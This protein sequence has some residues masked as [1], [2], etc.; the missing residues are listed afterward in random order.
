M[1]AGGAGAILPN[2]FTTKHNFRYVPRMNGPDLVKKLRAQLDANGY[3]DVEVKLIGDVPW[4]RGSSP[5]T[6]IAHAHQKAGELMASIGLGG[7]GRGGAPVL[8]TSARLTDPNALLSDTAAD[9]AGGYWPAYLFA[10]GETG[11]KIGSVSIPMGGRGGGG[12]GGRAHAANEFY[13]VEST[14]TSGGLANAE[15]NAAAAIYQY[16]QLTTV[17]PK[18]KATAGK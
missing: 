17:T 7:G 3:K 6:D 8:P 15:K 18:P 2:K 9:P 16:A 5:D 13:T 4:S 11:Q 1:Y 14:G 10:D 12:G